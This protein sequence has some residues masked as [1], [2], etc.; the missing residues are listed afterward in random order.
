MGTEATQPIKDGNVRVL[1]LLA[2][3]AAFVCAAAPIGA[4]AKTRAHKHPTRSHRPP[5]RSPVA[6]AGLAVSAMNGLGAARLGPRHFDQQLAAMQSRGVQVVRIDAPWA[7]IE[8]Q[9]PGPAGHS[10]QFAQ[11]DAWAT[12]LAVHHLT[13]EPLLDYSVGWAKTCAG[14]CGP[15]DDSAYAAFAKAVAARYGEHGSF[16][17][18]HPKLPYYPARIFEVWNEENT[19]SYWSTGPSA[20][21]YARLYIAARAAIKAVDP[22]ASVIVGGLAG[23]NIAFNLQQDGPAQFVQQML[24]AQPGLRGHIDGFGLHPYAPTAQ[25]SVEWVVH[26]R[27]VLDSLGEGSAPID[28]TEFGWPAG[29]GPARE[30]WRA[31]EMLTFGLYLAHSNC[32]IRLVAPYDWVNPLYAQDSPDFGLVDRTGL[33]TSLRKSGSTWFYALKL[34]A[35]KPEQMT[36]SA[37]GPGRHGHALGGGGGLGAGGLPGFGLAPPSGII[38]IFGLR[39]G[40][41]ASG[42]ASARSGQRCWLSQQPWKTWL[43]AARLPEAS[44]IRRSTVKRPC[45]SRV[46]VI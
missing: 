14:I 23:P 30:T 24:A 32:G 11:T 42:P 6:P 33:G 10:W 43:L 36:C 29:A 20:R 31:W 2:L 22:A 9:P 44:W 16:W 26:F 8:P 37:G 28:I 19:S 35:S 25:D 1:L 3:L 17:A 7:V 40:A 18:Q 45:G 21:Q 34:A 27:Q 4:S 39:L 41:G 38:N 46:S 5:A 15:T 13:W 12:A